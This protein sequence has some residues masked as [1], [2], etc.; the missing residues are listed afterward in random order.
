MD[1]LLESLFVNNSGL[2][3]IEAYLDRFNPLS[4][5]RVD[6][7]EIRHSNVLAWLLE[8]N[9]SHGLGDRFLRAFL[10]EVCRGRQSPKALDVIRADLRDVMI[11]REWRNVDILALSPS[12]GWAVVIEN[13]VK[14]RLTPG[15]LARYRNDVQSAYGAS[16]VVGVLL[17]VR[18]ESPDDKGWVSLGYDWVLSVLEELMGATPNLS[19][20]V[21]TFLGHYVETLGE[22]TGLNAEKDRM[23]KLARE[24]YV[25][26]RKALDFIME[27]AQSELRI[28]ADRVFEGGQ[29]GDICKSNARMIGFVP[30]A[31]KEILHAEGAVWEGC[32]RWWGGLPLACFFELRW[33]EGRDDG[34]LALV[35][36]V[37]PLQDNRLRVDLIET[38][39]TAIGDPKKVK[40]NNAARNESARYS[41][42]L[43]G[44][45]KPIDN[46]FDPIEL[47]KKM[48]KLLEDWHE[49]FGKI[50]ENGL[51]EFVERAKQR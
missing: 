32:K 28:A 17:S 30:P 3:R 25:A 8:P 6:S 16:E 23:E 45:R 41:R 47:E 5:L 24:L 40:F 48:R 15:Q 22:H 37:G 11:R 13:K 34:S 44:A 26:H 29:H 14:S 36:E 7:A 27:Q 9:G 2:A 10:G 31:W 35:A 1:A 46:C 19:Q 18:D 20:E 33:R 12:N 39:E 42:F 49:V 4:V 38:V 21:A 50:A 43:K 51:R